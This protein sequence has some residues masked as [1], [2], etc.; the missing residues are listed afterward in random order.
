MAHQMELRQIADYPRYYVTDLGLVWST[1]T[2]DWV[3]QKLGDRG[4]YSVYLS[5]KGRLKTIKVHKLVAEAFISKR[6]EGM[7]INH[8]NG[9]KTDNSLTNLEF[10]SQTQNIRHAY[11]LG[12]VHTLSGEKCGASTLTEKQVKRIVS[13]EF[14]GLSNEKTAKL[15]GVTAT[16]IQRI[17]NGV[18][19]SSVTGISRRINV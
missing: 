7:T 10:V 13:P 14:V 5:K 12:L 9:T 3:K 16:T 6:P 17:R 19:W 2:G 18:C 4:Y 15:F 1:N 11:S 8:K